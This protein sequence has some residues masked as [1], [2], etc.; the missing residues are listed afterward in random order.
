MPPNMDKPLATPFFQGFEPIIFKDSKLLIL[1]SFPSV[2]SRLVGFYYGNPQNRFWDTLSHAVG[3]NAPDDNGQKKEFLRRHKVALWD[4]IEMCAI[5]GSSDCD[6]KKDNSYVA[7]VKGVIKK[8]QNLCAVICNGKKSFNVFN[9][10]YPNATI[11]VIYLPSTSRRNPRF[12]EREWT[13]TIRK[14]LEL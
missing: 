1:G 4:V 3:E 9:E 2:K 10:I 8:S 14:Y 13:D 7:D 6:I 11:P 12:C 5:T